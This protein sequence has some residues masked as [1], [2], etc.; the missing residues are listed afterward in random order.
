MGL[1]LLLAGATVGVLFG[2]L[3]QL[4]DRRSLKEYQKRKELSCAHKKLGKL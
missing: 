3:I 1:I 4:H 2:A